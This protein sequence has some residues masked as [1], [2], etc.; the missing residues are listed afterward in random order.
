MSS[1]CQSRPVLRMPD[2][3]E[4]PSLAPEA[5]VQSEID[6][7]ADLDRQQ[8]MLPIR[9]AALLGPKKVVCWR[10]LNFSRSLLLKNREATK[11]IFCGK[12]S[13]FRSCVCCWL[14]SSTWTLYAA[15]SIRKIESS[16]GW[17]KWKFRLLEISPGDSE[18]GEAL[19]QRRASMSQI[20]PLL[21][22][23]LV[24]FNFEILI[25]KVADDCSSCERRQRRTGR[26]RIGCKCCKNFEASQ[27]RLTSRRFFAPAI[28][29]YLLILTAPWPSSSFTSLSSFV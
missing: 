23:Q 26:D 27:R 25:S 18:W 22:P 11:E 16:V 13:E 9:W 5:Q 20:S 2:E 21:F 10:S 17:E 8:I 19:L 1:W 28:I 7:D 3:S 15:L 6:V 4:P 24:G 29:F 12:R 14:A